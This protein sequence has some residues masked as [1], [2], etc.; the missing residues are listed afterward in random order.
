M[1]DPFKPQSSQQLIREAK[2]GLSV[3]ALLFATLIY[4]GTLR[5]TGQTPPFSVSQ[6]V[7][8]QST[9]TVRHSPIETLTGSETIN[10]SKTF[11]PGKGI[12]PSSN[13][14]I[15]KNIEPPRVGQ[16]FPPRATRAPRAASTRPNFQIKAQPTPKAST[17]NDVQP[18]NLKSN[19]GM[20]VPL[21]TKISAINPNVSKIKPNPLGSA[22]KTGRVFHAQF[23][24]NLSQFENPREPT[25]ITPITSRNSS[26][27][28][29]SKQS[30]QQLTTNYSP[31]TEAHNQ[32]KLILAPIQFTNVL[33]R[34]PNDETLKQKTSKPLTQ[35]VNELKTPSNF[36]PPDLKLSKKLP[37][38]EAQKNSQTYKTKP[39]D[40]YWSVSVETYED[41][42]YFRALFRHNQS[43]HADYKLTSGL[44]LKT[45]AQHELERLWP[46]ECPTTSEANTSVENVTS[47]ETI[48]YHVT[49]KGETLFEIARQKL[50]QGSRFVELY[51]LNL[52]SLGEDTHPDSSLPN[53]LKL[54]LPK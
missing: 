46:N 6:M 36:I 40:T 29:P 23:E 31:P 20:F 1:A 35:S 44:E 39:G 16:L 47:V 48:A 14:V 5:I 15:G 37:R 2:L 22:K 34:L 11:L 9:K 10:P 3:V 30:T 27:L 41:G 12:S 17:P 28:H 51:Q 43:I 50:N 45:P 18:A 7:G 52:D 26:F 42:R 54:I 4:V 53:G 21:E 32:S 25:P 38:A 24:S 13:E 19:G 33:P 8:F 49:S